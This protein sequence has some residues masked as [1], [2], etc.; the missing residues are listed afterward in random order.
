MISVG[1]ETYGRV[2]P[3][4]GISIITEFWMFCSVPVIPLQSFYVRESRQSQ[5]HGLP[6]LAEM[7]ND[8]VRGIPL[9]HADRASILAAYVRA[10][11]VVPLLF[12]FMIVFPF[13]S[14]SRINRRETTP[15]SRRLTS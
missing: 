2:K 6:I 14:S 7:R 9:Q 1:N 4:S 3:V 15:S 12:G 11:C 13:S 8:A 5:S 10:G